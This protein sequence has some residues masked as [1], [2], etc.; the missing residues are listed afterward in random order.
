MRAYSI[1]HPPGVTRALRTRTAAET[2][3]CDNPR[4]HPVLFV[5]TAFLVCAFLFL[6][7]GAWR[8]NRGLS[9]PRPF[10]ER[11]AIAI[12]FATVGLQALV[13]LGADHPRATEAR[14]VAVWLQ[15][16]CSFGISA[17]A[18]ASG[19]LVSPRTGAD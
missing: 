19:R 11:A 8:V 7:V 1:T 15:L 12:I 9:A 6:C 13:W 3:L 2:R 5:T 10:A 14:V 16:L 4:M 18:L 17:V